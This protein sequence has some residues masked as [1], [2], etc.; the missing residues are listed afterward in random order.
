VLLTPEQL[1]LK[2]SVGETDYANIKS[3][4]GGGVVFDSIPG[5]VYPFRITEI[6]LTPT[7]TQGVV[8]YQVKASLVLAPDATRPSPGMNARGQIITDSKPN[9]LAVPPRAIRR[10]GND[11]VVDVRRNG[12]VEEQIITTG[13]TDN[14]QVEIVTGLNEGDVVVVPSLASPRPGSTPKAQPT[15]PGGVK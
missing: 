6:G 13:A 11:Q 14:Q 5:K 7:V 1:I 9:V 12:G 3:G 15:L 8:T 4:Q 10:S 2:M